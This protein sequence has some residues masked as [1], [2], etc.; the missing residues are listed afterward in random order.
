MRESTK[1]E[2]T[3]KKLQPPHPFIVIFA[4]MAFALVLTFLVPLGRYE[5]KQVTT[6]VGGEQKTETVVDP[7]SFRYILDEN[8]ER[9]VYPAPLFGPS[10]HGRQG[11]MNVLFSGL[12]YG[13]QAA[14]T[15]GLIAYMLV[16]GGS[17]GILMRTGV[18]D[19]YILRVLHR[20]EGVV[21]LFPPLLFV[22]FSLAGAMFGFSEGAIPLAI[23]IIPLLIGMDFD[24]V[25]GVLVTFVATQLGITASWCS[26]KALTTAQ[27]IAGVPVFSGAQYRFVLWL[28]L[29]LAG[30][31]YTTW[32]AWRI[33]TSTHR[34]VSYQSDARCRGRLQNLR[35]RREPL[36]L[37]GRLVLLT[38]GFSIAWML[39]GTIN[40]E[41]GLADIASLFFV[42]AVVVGVLGTVFHLGGM[43]F[44]DIPRAFQSGASDLVGAVLVVGMAQGMVLLL[45]G[46][47]PTDA[48]VLNTILHWTARVLRELP[49]VLTSWLMYIFHFWLSF[50]VPSD[51]GQAALTMPVMAPLADGLGISRQIAVLAFQIGGCLAHLIM[52]TSGCLIGILSIARL[53][54]GDWLRSQWKALLVVFGVG[55]LA[56]TAGFFMGYA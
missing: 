33:H 41:Y 30:A 9:V 4:A 48:S 45:G 11:M 53:E 36:T 42:M 49:S 38:V 37:G 6:L 31:A 8:G 17:F 32:Y 21:M 51:T 22:L 46:I 2:K 27:T 54:W 40:M 52:P 7:E 10:A 50:V 24:A 16:I 28:V 55:F 39:W 26:P 18:I 23:L 5:L 19:Q 44:A 13:E 25:T 56:L 15:A 34:S 47:N 3:R 1:T 29:T 14:G 43:H 20:T 35:E 12:E